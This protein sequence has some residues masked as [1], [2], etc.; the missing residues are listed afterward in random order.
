MIEIDVECYFHP[1]GQGLFS[2]GVIKFDGG[3]YRDEFQWVYDCGTTSSQR[4]LRAALSKFQRLRRNTPLDLVVISHFDADHIS[5]LVKLLNEV[6]TDILMLPWAPLW[7]RLAIGCAQGLTPDDPDFEFYIDPVQYLNDQAGDGFRRI[8]FIPFSVGEGPPEP[9]D[10]T[11]PTE[12]GPDGRPKLQLDFE[13]EFESEDSH[14]LMQYE[15]NAGMYREVIMMRKGSSA[16]FLGLWEFVPYNDPATQPKN[17]PNFIQNVNDLR[18]HLLNTSESERKHAL[19][20]LKEFYRRSFP[21]SQSNDLSL[22]IYSGPIGVWNTQI[23]P[24]HCDYGSE[25]GRKA[26]IIYTGDGNLASQQKWQNF[27][28]YLGDQRAISPSIF[29]V[30]HHGSRKNWFDG[31]ADQIEPHSSIFS[32]DPSHRSF[33]HPHREVLR[34][35]WPHQAVQVDKE[36]GFR[37]RA[38][39][40]KYR[41]M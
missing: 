16:R 21:K 14:E 26:S 18:E 2:S 39:L 38:W 40:K 1:V 34:D 27:R 31:L 15:R 20:K 6:G 10:E 3:R 32:S 23:H 33:G 7:H 13:K 9:E 12:E 19:Y 24:W 11:G 36:S 29:Q 25:N 41:H 8:V 4:L 28:K 35:F 17:V 5:G 22:F 37:S 30:P